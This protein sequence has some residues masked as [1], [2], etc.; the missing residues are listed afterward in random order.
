MLCLGT[1]EEA[2][3]RLLAHLDSGMHSCAYN[4]VSVKQPPQ[5]V[6]ESAEE[7]VQ[8]DIQLVQDKQTESSATENA[9]SSGNKSD[10]QNFCREPMADVGDTA[11]NGREQC[12]MCDTG[13]YMVAAD[14]WEYLPDKLCRLC[15][16]S[17]EHPKQSIVGWLHML[18]EIIPDLVS[19][20]FLFTD[21][22]TLALVQI[23][24]R[25]VIYSS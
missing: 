3:S 23:M 10:L 6:Q 13:S 17:D 15:A 25:C 18:N 1:C 16:S 14:T 4:N 2:G 20:L 19:Y 7:P 22:C 8:E 5:E 9:S 24:Y 21:L 11:V 12:E